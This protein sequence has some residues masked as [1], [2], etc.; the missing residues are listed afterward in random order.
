MPHPNQEV[1]R[2][3]DGNLRFYKNSIV[4]FLYRAGPFDMSQLSLMPFSEEDRK[5]FYQLIG[6]S[7]SGY[8]ELGFKKD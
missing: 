3:A 2:D 6:Y 4:E 1:I 8:E 5:Q 7:L